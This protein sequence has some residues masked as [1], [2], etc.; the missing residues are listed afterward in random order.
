MNDAKK[1]T[2]DLSYSFEK[3]RE[4]HPG[5]Y[6]PWT[7]EDDHKPEQDYGNGISIEDL[8]KASGRTK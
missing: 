2:K 3:F 4:K 6:F 5:A 1:D 8:A 7:K